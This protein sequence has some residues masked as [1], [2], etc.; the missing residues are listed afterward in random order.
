MECGGV[1]GAIG[2]SSCQRMLYARLE[3]DVDQTEDAELRRL[4][5]GASDA[6]GHGVPASSQVALR[7]K[8]QRVRR[9]R[10]TIR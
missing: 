4:E 10:D 2:L 6:M 1:T 3:S 8:Q 5:A 9:R 7:R